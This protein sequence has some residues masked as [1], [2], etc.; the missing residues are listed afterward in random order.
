MMDKPTGVPGLHLSRTV[1]LGNGHEVTITLRRTAAWAIE[2]I[3]L[4]TIGVEDI[5][6][7]A[8]GPYASEDEALAAGVRIAEDALAAGA[9]HADE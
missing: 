4:E 3:D 8:G 5:E 7:S 9:G 1:A 2:L 6:H